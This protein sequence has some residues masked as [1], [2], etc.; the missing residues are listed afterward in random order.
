MKQSQQV[1]NLSCSKSTTTKK[2]PGR[3]RTTSRNHQSDQPTTST[4]THRGR[5]RPPKL[6]GVQYQTQNKQQQH[7]RNQLTAHNDRQP[8]VSKT[9]YR[10]LYVGHI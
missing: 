7:K 1:T 10:L 3:Q 8:Q 6:A 5:G 4:T 9:D 2:L